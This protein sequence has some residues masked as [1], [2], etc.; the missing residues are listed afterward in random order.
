MIMSNTRDMGI[1]RWSEKKEEIDIHKAKNNE[2]TNFK[3]FILINI[4][5][6]AN[7]TKAHEVSCNI[8]PD[9]MIIKF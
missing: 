6:V 1:L 3:I 9:I 2:V 4:V 7:S 8:K 5:V